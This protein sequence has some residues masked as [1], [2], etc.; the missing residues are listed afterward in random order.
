MSD[1]Q[2]PYSCGNEDVDRFV[3]VVL[4]TSWMM[5][6]LVENLVEGL[7][8]DA[9]PGESKGAAVVEMLFGSMATALD[10][11]DSSEIMRA[12]DLI[13]LTSDRVI[14]HL[15]LAEQLSLRLHG[16]DGVGR[17]YG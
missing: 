9:F 4:R 12:A 11:V 6:D 14:E 7:R 15:R 10:S 17:N 3:L 2:W 8:E 1:E 13:E 16:G 5:C